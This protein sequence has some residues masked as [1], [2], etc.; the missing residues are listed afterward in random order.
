[1]KKILILCLFL[2]GCEKYEYT[3]NYTRD[4]EITG[5]IEYR[6]SDDTWITKKYTLINFV[7]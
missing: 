3:S 2:F 1:M 5:D 7:K 6:Q 4:N